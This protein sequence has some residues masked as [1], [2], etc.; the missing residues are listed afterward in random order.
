VTTSSCQD[1]YN[2]ISDSPFGALYRRHYNPVHV[3]LLLLL[4]LYYFFYTYA[5]TLWYARYYIRPGETRNVGVSRNVTP[6]LL[7]LNTPAQ[8]AI[9]EIYYVLRRMRSDIIHSR[10]CVIQRVH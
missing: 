3:L 8:T 4:L 1:R 5:Y 9:L 2:E 7:L 10:K 6:I